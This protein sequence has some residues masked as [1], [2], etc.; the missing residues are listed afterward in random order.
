ME[1][2]NEPED[3]TLR[4]DERLPVTN[5]GSYY[6]IYQEAIGLLRKR[7]LHLS[8]APIDYQGNIV[9]PFLPERLDNLTPQEAQKLLGE[10]SAYL[11]YA[12]SELASLQMELDGWERAK[13]F[14]RS[15]LRA[16]CSSRSSTALADAIN[17]DTR[18]QELDKKEYSA[19]VKAELA[20][21]VVD[22]VERHFF[23]I[24]RIITA[25]GHE[26]ERGQRE[27]YVAPKRDGQ[28]SATHLT[29]QALAKT[30]LFRQGQ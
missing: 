2:K 1:N 19:K 7:G 11:E 14:F 8:P 4:L 18:Y 30:K 9:R 26:I 27:H 3:V 12:Q 5:R 15:Q 16:Q 20:K 25:Q 13:T 28:F 17:N 22:A 6:K 21:A 24:S 29:Q 23:C 10:F